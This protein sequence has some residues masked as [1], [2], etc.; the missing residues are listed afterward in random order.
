MLTRASD[1]IG[2]LS[3][4]QSDVF[5]LPRS[6]ALSRDRAPCVN[7]PKQLHGCLILAIFRAYCHGG[8]RIAIPAPIFDSKARDFR[9]RPVVAGSSDRWPAPATRVARQRRMRQRRTFRGCR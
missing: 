5:R 2:H 3:D 6:Q 4:I 1:R 7:P 8:D 9:P